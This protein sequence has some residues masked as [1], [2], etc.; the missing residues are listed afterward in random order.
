M[1]GLVQ[2]CRAGFVLQVETHAKIL[3]DIDALYYGVNFA[4]DLIFVT[5]TQRAPKVAE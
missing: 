1:F 5:K 4:E 3:S 2:T